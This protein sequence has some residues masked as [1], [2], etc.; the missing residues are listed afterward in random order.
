MLQLSDLKIGM[1]VRITESCFKSKFNGKTAVIKAI[2]P[3]SIYL[4]RV[5]ITDDVD[6]VAKSIL[7]YFKDSY[8]LKLDEFE[9]CYQPG[10]QMLLFS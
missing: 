2:Y 5:N 9:R 4:I 7:N 8:P 10:E 6:D 1:K 3:D